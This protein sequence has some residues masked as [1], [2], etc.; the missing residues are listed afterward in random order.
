MIGNA[1]RISAKTGRGL[2]ALLESI[3]ENLPV[4]TTKGGIVASFCTERACGKAAE[5]WECAGGGEYTENGLN[6]RHRLTQRCSTLVQEYVI[7]PGGIKNKIFASLACGRLERGIGK[8]YCLREGPAYIG[9]APHKIDKTPH[10][11]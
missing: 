9:K 3:E 6:L 11:A 2:D 4:K 1:V 5:R 10:P 8:R 7:F